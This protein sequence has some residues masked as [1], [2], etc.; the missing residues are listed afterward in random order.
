MSLKTDGTR[1]NL[2]SED[3]SAF[4]FRKEQERSETHHYGYCVCLIDFCSVSWLA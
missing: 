3:C 4:W 1:E 2:R